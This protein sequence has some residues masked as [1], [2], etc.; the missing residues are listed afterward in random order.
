MNSIQVGLQSDEIDFQNGVVTLGRCM[1][2]T[3]EE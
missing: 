1:E 3:S 2:K